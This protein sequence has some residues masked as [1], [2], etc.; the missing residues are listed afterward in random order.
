MLMRKLIYCIYK[1]RKNSQAINP[2][3]FFLAKVISVVCLSF[4]IA[5]CGQTGPE[6]QKFL[7][8]VINPNQGTQDMN[9]GFIEGL[10]D[11]GYVAGKNATFI[12]ALNKTE[13]DKALQEMLKKNADLIFTVTTP[14]TK[15]A[16][17]AA[18]TKDIPVI[19]ALHD[20]VSSGVIKS[21]STVNKNITGVQ[22]R[23]SV[24]KA[25]DWLL[26][27]S[28][29]IDTI[30][31]PVT[32]DTP[33]SQESLDDLRKA[34]LTKD[35]NLVLREINTPSD[36]P[37]IFQN[38]PE[39]IDAVFLIHSIFIS[40]HTEKIVREAAKRKLPVG[41]GTSTY[42]KGALITFGVSAIEVGRQA[43]RMAFQILQGIKTENIPVETAEFYLG[44]NLETAHIAD[45]QVSNTILSRADFIIPYKEK[46]SQ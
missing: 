28:P 19:F 25:L 1:K 35:I 44:I 41:G 24:P 21:L 11:Q 26:R 6:S 16:V 36:I 32:F 40:S 31:V 34:A 3:L 45:I 10:A 4:I 9:K 33:A 37:L 8:G 5:S 43:S 42:H 18:K 7:I 38:M 17:A 23:G 13:I 15:K 12:T 29:D 27:L 20:P 2:Q 46:E 22:I 39:N 14:A 30:L